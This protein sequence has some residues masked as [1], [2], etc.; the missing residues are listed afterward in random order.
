MKQKTLQCK[1]ESV[2]RYG[3]CEVC[4]RLT[5]PFAYH[6]YITSI[7]LLDAEKASGI[8]SDAD[9]ME[10]QAKLDFIKE[11]SLNNNLWRPY[12][13]DTHGF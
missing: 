11:Y 3:I 1:H 2:D 7:L 4:G 6:L 12:T 5:K 13:L 9:Y 10:R 8:I